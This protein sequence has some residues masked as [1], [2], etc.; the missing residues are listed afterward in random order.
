LEC[1][2]DKGRFHAEV[3]RK[4]PEEFETAME[5]GTDGKRCC[6]FP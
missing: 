1:D 5:S 3:K 2:L 6:V 4:H